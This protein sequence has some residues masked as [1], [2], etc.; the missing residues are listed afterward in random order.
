[1]IARNKCSVTTLSQL[2]AEFEAKSTAFVELVKSRESMPPEDF[3]Q[4]ARQLLRD[5]KTTAEQ[6]KACAR[7]LEDPSQYIKT[8]ATQYGLSVDG[9]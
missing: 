4:S 8:F 1:M 2:A 7:N 6:L 5:L 9:L 3:L